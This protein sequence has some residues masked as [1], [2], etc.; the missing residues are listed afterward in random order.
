MVI[1]LSLVEGFRG[2]DG[3]LFFEMSQSNGRKLLLHAN[4]V[5][6]LDEIFKN[7]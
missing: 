5:K 2:I 6:N 7:L 4:K 3:T 1:N